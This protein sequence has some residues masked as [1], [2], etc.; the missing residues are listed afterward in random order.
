VTRTVVVAGTAGGV[1]TT[2]VAALIA[3]VAPAVG[4]LDHT[5]G[6]LVARGAP[7]DPLATS[8][9]VVHDLGAHALGRGAAALTAPDA[10][11]VIVT[12]ATPA[13]IADAA[14]S[15]DALGP[16]AR[17]ANLVVVESF[18]RHDVS[19]AV[20]GVRQRFDGLAVVTLAQD[21]ALAAGGAIAPER[22]SLRTR[23]AIEQ[24]VAA[25]R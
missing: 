6:Q 12:A 2:T 9:L 23:H 8:A 24:L 14:A 5:S 17:T 18:G 11:A 19:G 10:I 15:L 21:R 4:L 22:T 16:A 1:G 13:G 20:R 3:L 7:R 25:L